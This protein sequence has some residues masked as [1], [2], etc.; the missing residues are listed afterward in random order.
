MVDISVII[1]V[2]NAGMFLAKTLESVNKQTFSNYEL[3]IVNDGSTDNSSEII[4][5]YFLIHQS[6][7]TVIKQENKGQ[8]VARNVGVERASGKYIVFMDADDLIETDFLEVLFRSVTSNDADGALCGWKEIDENDNLIGR[9]RSVQN[10]VVKFNNGYEHIFH[11]SPCGR[12]TKRSFLL[13]NKITFSKGEQ[14]ED[15]PYCMELSCVSQKINVISRNMYLYRQYSSSTVGSLHN[16]N[17]VPKVAYNGLEQSIIRIQRNENCSED[18]L[19]YCSIKIM[20]GWLT[21][22]Y[23]YV[24]VKGFRKDLAEY[25]YRIIDTYFPNIKKNKLLNLHSAKELPFGHRL[26]IVLFCQT[27]RLHCLE[28]FSKITSFVLGSL[29]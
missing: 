23:C 15:G 8:S 28:F 13:E 19:E 22:I 29:M 16:K 7:T 25:C 1:P 10:W 26:A 24:K 3:I 14:M 27:Y 4:N 12:I 2:Y 18:I 11:Y 21:N 6:N 20:T 9:E 5:N 17:V